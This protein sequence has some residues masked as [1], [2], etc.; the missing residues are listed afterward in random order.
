MLT[1]RNTHEKIS[2]NH[3]ILTRKNFRLTKYPREKIWVP[4]NTHQ[5][6]FRIYE[7]PTSHNGKMTLDPQDPR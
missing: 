7:I 6:I 3:E 5:K 1:Q 2:L 4:Q